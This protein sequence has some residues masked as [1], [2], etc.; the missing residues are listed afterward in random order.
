M[1]FLSFIEFEPI[2]LGFAGAL[3]IFGLVIVGTFFLTQ[4][5]PSSERLS[6][7]L[8]KL[9]RDLLKAENKI[10]RINNGIDVNRD[11]LP[12]LEQE[13]DKLKVRI[14]CVKESLDKLRMLAES[15]T[16]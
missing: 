7:E 15:A 2:I 6:E 16:S 4:R 5:K 10:G 11:K 12:A 8:Q 9:N 13:R 1:H 3:V 14:V